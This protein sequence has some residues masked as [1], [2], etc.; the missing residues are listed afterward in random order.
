LRF[1]VQGG[2]IDA[3]LKELRES[4]LDLV[5]WVS[6]TGPVMETRHYWTEELVWLRAA[7][8]R[9]DPL[10]PVP[11]VSYGEECLFTR[12]ALAGLSREGRESEVVLTGSSIVGLGAAVAAGI[13]VMAL[14]RSRANIPGVVIWDDAPL[15]RL[16]EIFC[17]IY[18][19]GGPESEDR[20]Q[21]A[22]AIA[23]A[24]R[25]Q[26]HA[27]PAVRAEVAAASV[28]ALPSV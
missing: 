6:A 25:G 22:D 14:P 28:E 18:V 17:G 26:R 2:N 9:L 11:L 13:G 23:T 16:P 3:L 4:D 20:E 21:L 27:S 12:N 8:A 24:L 15:P 19:R 7:S 1:V 5:V 10:G